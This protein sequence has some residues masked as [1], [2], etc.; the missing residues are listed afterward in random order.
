MGQEHMVTAKCNW[1]CPLYRLTCANKEIVQACKNNGLKAVHEHRYAK[2]HVSFHMSTY[3][4]SPAQACI[5]TEAT[6]VSKQVEHTVGAP[7]ASP[8]EG[9]IVALIQEEAALLALHYVSL[10]EAQG[11]K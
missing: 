1:N 4:F 9:A 11:K 8:N 5:Y 6:R 7:C 10:H 3:L 2:L